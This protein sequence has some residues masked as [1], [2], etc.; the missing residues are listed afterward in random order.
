MSAPPDPQS[1]G[2][3]RLIGTVLL[4][5]G[6]LWVLLSG[7]CTLAFGVG[8]LTS[9]EWEGVGLALFIGVP[10]VAAGCGV[11]LLGRFLRRA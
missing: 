1:T 10:V 2:M 6:G 3:R 7:L 11:Y 5:I 9:G 4:V 8:F